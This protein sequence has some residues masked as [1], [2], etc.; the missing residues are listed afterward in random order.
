MRDIIK[1]VRKKGVIMMLYN[2]DTERINR[3]LHNLVQCVTVVEMSRGMLYR[4]AVLDSY[5]GAPALHIGVEC[6]M[7]VRS[8]MVEG[9]ITR[10]TGS[11]CD[12]IDIFEDGQVIPTEE[13]DWM[14]KLIRFRDRLMRH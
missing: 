14:N 11:Y 13:A 12:I 9:C 6:M 8:C 7:D 5:A 10:E 4:G 2:V 3:Q 1:A